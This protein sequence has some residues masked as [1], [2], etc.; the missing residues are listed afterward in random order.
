MEHST[1]KLGMM[2]TVA[3]WILGFLLLALVFA[4]ILD[5]Q[6]NPNQSVSTV[7]GAGTQEIVLQRNRSGH[8]VFNGEINHQ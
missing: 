1:K 2:F 4:R 5:Q 3:G 8:Y 6:N 7:L